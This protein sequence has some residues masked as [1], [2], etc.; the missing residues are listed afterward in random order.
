MACPGGLPLQ[1]SAIYGVWMD[2]GCVNTIKRVAG[3][4]VV[5][6]NL[7]ISLLQMCL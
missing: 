3:D 1:S 7:N 5:I 6:S 2:K 4:H